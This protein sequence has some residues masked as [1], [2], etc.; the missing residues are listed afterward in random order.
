MI[1]YINYWLVNYTTTTLAPGLKMQLLLLKEESKLV[2]QSA[3]EFVKNNHRT[4]I[5]SEP[6]T[7]VVFYEMITNNNAP[8]RVYNR[9]LEPIKNITY[10]HATDFSINR[11]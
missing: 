9:K 5:Y 4:T 1:N 7:S 3:I 10:P 2:V 6:N 11:S 8:V